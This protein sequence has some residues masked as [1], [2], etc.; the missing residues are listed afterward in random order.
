MR[1]ARCNVAVGP[2][3]VAHRNAAISAHP[4]APDRPWVTVH[5]A[6]AK[7]SARHKL[8]QRAPITSRALRVNTQATNAGCVTAAMRSCP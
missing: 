4:P 5:P 3:R 7:C 2:V 1:R 8:G 6:W